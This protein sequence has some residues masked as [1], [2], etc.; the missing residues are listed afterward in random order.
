MKRLGVRIGAA[1]GIAVIS[2]VAV[3]AARG[4]PIICPG[5]PC[6][7]TEASETLEGSEDADQ[8]DALGGD[9][10]L[11]GNGADDVLRGGEGGDTSYGNLGDDRHFGGPGQDFLSEGGPEGED[12]MAG[13]DGNDE[14]E[15]GGEADTLTGGSGNERGAVE[16]RAT[17]RRGDVSC[18]RGFC[19][20][21][22]GD[23][24]PDT[25]KG[26]EGKDYMEGEQ[27]RDV[28]NGGSGADVLDAVNEDTGQRDKV[29]CGKGR[30]VVFANPNDRVAD[31]CERVKP[32]QAK[33]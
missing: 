18:F 29:V 4:V 23:E 12:F 32:P 20:E 25:L 17:R 19:A 3:A 27:G 1:A 22:F 21:M 7:G 2:I 13:G 5:G 11:H 14:M 8:I 24:G 26:G 28:L 30:D 31:S 15:G 33:P 10:T 6:T 16:T 9:D